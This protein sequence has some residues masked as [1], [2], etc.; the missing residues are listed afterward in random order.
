MLVSDVYRD[1]LIYEESA[2]A[3]YIYYLLKEKIISLDDDI[4]KID[5][6]QANHQKVREMIQTNVLGFH[7][8]CVFSLKMDQNNFVFIFAAS[9]QEAIQFY[10]KTFQQ[11][12]LN[13]HEYTLDYQLSRGNDVI[14]F[15]DLR[16]EFTIFPAIAGYFKWE[17]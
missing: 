4:S 16:K 3:H 12:P 6:N 5:L 1:S 17:R 10:S 2:L 7:K 11:T 8:I 13:C 9:E 15:R 14:S